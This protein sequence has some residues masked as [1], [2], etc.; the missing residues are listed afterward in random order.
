MRGLAEKVSRSWFMLA[1]GGLAL[2][3]LA[4]LQ[5]YSP[6]EAYAEDNAQVV[7]AVIDAATR[8]LQ[9]QIDAK[10][11]EIQQLEALAQSY[12]NTIA[13]TQ[14]QSQTLKNKIQQ[15]SQTVNKLKTEIRLAQTQIA[16]TNLEIGGLQ[17]KIDAATIEIKQKQRDLGLLLQSLAAS[18]EKNL[19][20]VLLQYDHLSDFATYMQG[21]EDLQKRV[22]QTLGEVKILRQSLTMIKQ[23]PRARLKT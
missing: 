8:A 10:T 23:K 14:S 22:Y 3:S 12:K 2:L 21:I 17:S 4:F 1:A 20:E 15:I 7:T 19:V 13:S 9:Q 5:I 6:I 16:R 18:N 11:K